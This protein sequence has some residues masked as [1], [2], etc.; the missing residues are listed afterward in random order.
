MRPSQDSSDSHESLGAGDSGIPSG[1][2]VTGDS[3]HSSLTHGTFTTPQEALLH[4][5]VVRWRRF[6]LLCIAFVMACTAMAPWLRGDPLL[7]L[8]FYTAI[9]IAVVSMLAFYLYIKDERRYSHS[10][11]LIMVGITGG[12]SLILCAF[13]GMFSPAPMIFML[14]IS[15]YSPGSSKV[16]ALVAYLGCALM[17]AAGMFLISTGILPDLGIIRAD[18]VPLQEKIIIALG[19]QVFLFSSYLFGRMARHSTKA[20]VEKLERA[21]RQVSQRD[22][23]LHEANQMLDRA[24]AL[25]A[26]EGRYSGEQ[27]GDWHLGRLLGRG[28]MGEVYEGQHA[29]DGTS[30]AVKILYPEVQCEPDRIKRFLREAEIMSRL[31][32]PHVV[33]ILGLGDGSEGPPFIAMERLEGKDLHV[34]LRKKRRLKPREVLRVVSQVALALDAARQ[35]NVVHRDIKPQNILLAGPSGVQTW[36]VLDFGISKISEGAATVTGRPIGTPGYMAPEQASSEEV[37][38]R[39]DVFSLAAVA[40][41]ALTGRP[42]FSGSDPVTVMFDIVYRQPVRPTELV[43]L[44]DDVDCIM[45]LALAKDPDDRP[46]TSL[47]FARALEDALAGRLDESERERGAVLIARYPWGSSRSSTFASSSESTRSSESA[48]L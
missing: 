36:K 38:H 23:L 17:L 41:R 44:P 22:A 2:G 27:V 25:Q 21:I 15:F 40:Y 45:A 8:L 3:D 26:G 37:D 12:A 43:K 5:E 24:R 11:G 28:A 33:R 6:M 39:A 18:S 47:E 13:I 10:K 20:A 7:K 9:G 16:A 35:A 1:T 48:S 29:T 46:A 42:A 30:A 4:D 34:H 31:D 19:I 32:S 14:G